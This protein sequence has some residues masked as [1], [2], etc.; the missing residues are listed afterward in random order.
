MTRKTEIDQSEYNKLKFF[1]QYILKKF[2]IGDFIPEEDR[3]I[4]VLE[5]LE[6]QNMKLA[7]KGLQHAINDTME[8]TKFLS[9]EEVRSFDRDLKHAGAYTLTEIR[10]K[11]SKDVAKIMK[12]GRIIDNKEYYLIKSY[13]EIMNQGDADRI[14]VERLISEYE[15]I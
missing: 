9:I 8:K 7:I 5:R 15:K 4:S 10:I 3:P 14:A 1:L 2:P 13:L 12:R 11:F 6:K